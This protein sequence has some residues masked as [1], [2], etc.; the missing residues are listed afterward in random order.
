AIRVLNRRK[1]YSCKFDPSEVSNLVIDGSLFPYGLVLD[2]HR[3]FRTR[4]EMQSRAAAVVEVDSKRFGKCTAPGLPSSKIEQFYSRLSRSHSQ[5]IVEIITK[6]LLKQL[7]L[8]F[9]L[10]PDHFL[11]GIVNPVRRL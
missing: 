1:L 6:A 11:A 5:Q 3:K 10:I 9:F 2:H 4:I 8:L 7:Y